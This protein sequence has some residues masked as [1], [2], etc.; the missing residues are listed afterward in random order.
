[1]HQEIT[2][3]LLQVEAESFI[4]DLKNKISQQILDGLS[5]NE[6][7]MNNS[8][9]IENLNKAERNNI[10]AE[11]DLIKNQVI[12]KG[13][14]SNKDF[15]SDIEELDDSRSFIVNVDNIENERPHELKEVF[16]IVSSDW[17][18]SLKIESIFEFCR[19]RVL[20]TN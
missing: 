6:I 12:A 1:M 18:D 19:I 3:T 11:N 20:I 14:A 5:L 8:L 9:S 15:V 7:A 17:I 13:F 2:D 4:I 10:Q 16:E